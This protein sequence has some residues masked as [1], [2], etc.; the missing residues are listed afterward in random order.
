MSG[1]LF[2]VLAATNKSINLLGVSNGDVL[3]FFPHLLAGVLL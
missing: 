1:S 2:A 3:S